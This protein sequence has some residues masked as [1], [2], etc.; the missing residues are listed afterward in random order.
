M[1]QNEHRFLNHGLIFPWAQ[2]VHFFPTFFFWSTKEVLFTATSLCLC[3]FFILTLVFWDNLNKSVSYCHK[4]L[5][6]KGGMV[7]MMN[8][9]FQTKQTWN[10]M[11]TLSNI[12]FWLGHIIFQRFSFIL[13]KMGILISMFIYFRLSVFILCLTTGIK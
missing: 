12:D 4:N 10:C 7:Q 3:I 5:S 6:K 13:Y 1:T 8:E 11:S 9:G 2:H